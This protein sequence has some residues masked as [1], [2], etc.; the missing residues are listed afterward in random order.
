MYARLRRKTPEDRLVVVGAIYAAM[1]I[2]TIFGV[3]VGIALL[4]TTSLLLDSRYQSAIKVI[5]WFTAGGVASG[6]YMCTAGLFFFR[7]RTARLAS[8]T[9]TS[10]L[11]GTP[12]TW[13]LVSHL[14]VNGAAIGFAVTQTIL[15]L[16]VTVTAIYTFDDLPWRD[17]GEALSA[18]Y[19]FFCQARSLNR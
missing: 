5:P 9:L 4:T 19:R 7:G 14:G 15:A 2:I 1:P 17:P 6:V 13:L 8:V 10:A 3:L 18:W 12:L 11:F 16:F